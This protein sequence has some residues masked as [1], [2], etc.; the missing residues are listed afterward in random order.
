M[1]LVARAQALEN[2]NGILDRR[3]LDLDGLEAPL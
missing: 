1:L 2:V 3:L